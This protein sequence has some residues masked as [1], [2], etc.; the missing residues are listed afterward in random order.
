M[1]L[2]HLKLNNRIYFIVD[3]DMDGFCACALFLNYLHKFIPSF[4]N[5]SY[6]FHRGK[7]HGIDLSLVDYSANLIVALDSSSNDYEEHA[8]LSN[9]SKD[10]LVIDHHMAEKVSEHACIINN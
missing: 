6:N 7:E 9:Q 4:N 3:S 10:I 1:L 5:Y 8:I 2:R